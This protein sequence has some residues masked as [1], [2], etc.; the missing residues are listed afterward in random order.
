MRDIQARLLGGQLFATATVHDLAGKQEGHVIAAVRNISLADVKRV[1]NSVSLKAVAI[2][3][4]VNATADATWTG[5]V[6]DVVVRSDAI[7]NA[8]V[9]AC[10]I[11]S[12]LVPCP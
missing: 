6:N 2:S 7:A 12:M 3:G 9:G 1:A 11:D 8:H 4:Q 10:A 5:S